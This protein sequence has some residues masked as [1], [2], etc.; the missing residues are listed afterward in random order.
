MAGFFGGFRGWVRARCVAVGLWKS[1]VP[2]S[3]WLGGSW[4]ALIG[5]ATVVG[6]GFIDGKPEQENVPKLSARSIHGRS[7]RV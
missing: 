7:V 1:V 3:G 5:A 2:V 4:D 6:A